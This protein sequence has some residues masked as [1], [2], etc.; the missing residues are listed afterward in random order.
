[1]ARSAAHARLR[2]P[3][4]THATA[5]PPLDIRAVLRAAEVTPPHIQQILKRY[6]T[7]V[8]RVLRTSPYRLT[9]EIAGLP[10]VAVDRLARTLG[11]NKGDRTRVQAGIH[12]TLQQGLRGG[13]TWLPLSRVVQRTAKLLSVPAALIEEQCLRGALDIGGA[14]LVEQQGA[15]TVLTSLALLTVE[16]RVAQALAD[17]LSCPLP[18]VVAN[19]AATVHQVSQARGLN[20]EQQQALHSALTTSVTII[21]GGPGTGKS[22][23]CQ[24]LAEVATHRHIPLL[25]GA[26]TGR[27]AQR[28]TEVSGLPAATLHRLL[29]YQPKD[30][31]FLHNEDYP[32]AT[33]LLVI[34]ETSMVDLFVFDAV[35]RA[36]PL[37]ARLVLIGDVDQL[38]SVGPGQVL[39][40][41]IAAGMASTVR[42]TQLYRRSAE[43]Q[44]T[45]SAHQIRDGQIPRLTDNP[46]SDCRFLEEADPERVIARVVD[47]V[48]H[49]IPATLSLDP[50]TDI[51]VLAPLNIGP[52]G[53][54][55]LN[56]ALQ[57][58]LN[59]VG[60]RVPLCSD[61]EF[62]VGDR[63][64]MTENNYRL[65]VFNGE[66]GTL[67]RAVP[68][69]HVAV[70]QT[71][72]DEVAVVG[73]ELAALT[74]GYATSVHRAQ[75]GEFPV[76]VLVLHDL[77]A[78]LLQ[79]TLL[80]TALT[81]AKRLCVIVGTRSAI[82]QAIHNIRALHRY[83]GLV[84]AIQRAGPRGQK[85]SA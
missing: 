30:N 69:K 15:E 68:E 26:P 79:R 77:H 57:Q 7:T 14:F 10:F 32:L 12:E 56:R 81:R 73:Q 65:N 29:A 25:A 59:P 24:A 27:A 39:A 58:R 46:Q 33:A 82:T 36:L 42:F 76:V 50:R 45:V 43:S 13:H 2:K 63:V 47:L 20:A 35:L 78:P 31:T 8:A 70:V 55:A 62:R 4:G 53:T 85:H 60:Q 51:Q 64:I 52:I 83:T 17:R 71:G 74:L 75:G 66:A 3:R 18:P 84:S 61:Q 37:T 34:D 40:D 41:V 1:M 21:T 67:I 19:V 38:P 22:Y 80:Y 9:R 5:A 48:A 54:H 23:F 16:Q 28:L 72:S 44:I 49:E 6:G 11:H